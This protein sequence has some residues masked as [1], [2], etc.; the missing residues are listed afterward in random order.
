MQC[1][2][3]TCDCPNP[4]TIGALGGAI[5]CDDCRT[6]Y[7]RGRPNRLADRDVSRPVYESPFTRRAHAGQ[8][9]EKVTR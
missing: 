8:L 9:P 2:C 4:A 3:S 5:R 6:G 1:P 7:H